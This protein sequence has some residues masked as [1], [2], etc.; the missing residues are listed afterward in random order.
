MQ[1]LACG[2]AVIAPKAPILSELYHA[3]YF[4]KLDSSSCRADLCAC[5]RA[6]GVDFIA[7]YATWSDLQDLTLFLIHH[8]LS[9]IALP[10]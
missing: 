9:N 5:A 7:L 10:D 1:D 3:P 4:V 2:K 6:K 8:V